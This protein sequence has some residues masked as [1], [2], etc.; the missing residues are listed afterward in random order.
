MMD[1]FFA[2]GVTS[3]HRRIVHREK[4]THPSRRSRRARRTFG[5]R[6][7]LLGRCDFSGARA[8]ETI[9]S[10]I[11]TRTD[12]TRSPSSDVDGTFFLF[13]KEVEDDPSDPRERRARRASCVVRVFR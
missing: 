6:D 11:Q 10:G 2:D 4:A 8:I 5:R 12:P 3:R 13:W 9:P 7:G 1:T